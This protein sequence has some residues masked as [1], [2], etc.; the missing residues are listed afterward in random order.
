MQ[1]KLRILFFLS[2]SLKYGIQTILWFMIHI[3]PPDKMVA[4][5]AASAA[6][7]ATA[8]AMINRSS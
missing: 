8:G 4:E 7:K 3:S 1:K 2:L 5:V 6:V